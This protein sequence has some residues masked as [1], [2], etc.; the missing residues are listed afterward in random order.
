MI[1]YLSMN[2]GSL[3]QFSLLWNKKIY[4]AKQVTTLHWIEV[5]CFASAV[6]PKMSCFAF[7][8]FSNIWG[9][10]RAIQLTLS[11]VSFQWW[12]L[13]R[14]KSDSQFVSEA[15]VELQKLAELVPGPVQPGPGQQ[16]GAGQSST[17]SEDTGTAQAQIR[18]H[19]DTTA[20]ST[21]KL[22]RRSQTEP[23]RLQR[24]LVPRDR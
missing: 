23:G 17:T 5:S 24:C 9:C 11:P 12:W 15:Q 20:G 8:M 4:Q 22:Q 2:E 18:D 7:S 1:W 10:F 14:V 19:T 3:S 21:A 13:Q 16:L 6:P